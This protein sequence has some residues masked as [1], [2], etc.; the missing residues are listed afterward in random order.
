MSDVGSEPGSWPVT[1]VRRGEPGPERQV[2]KVPVFFRQGQEVFV[3]HAVVN[4]QVRVRAPVI[5]KEAR[6]DPGA[7]VIAGDAETNGGGLREAEQKIRKVIAGAGH[8]KSVAEVAGAVTGEA[9]GAARIGVGLGI[10]LHAAQFASQVDIVF[11]TAPDQRVVGA[12][13]LGAGNRRERIA[14]PSKIGKPNRGDSPIKGVGG[15]PRNPQA[16]RQCPAETQT[17]SAKRFAGD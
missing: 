17:H 10:L 13:G 4:R 8:G 6:G 11:S 9:E 12:D 15:N 14:Q 5:L 3:P 1:T 16:P 2:R 7:E